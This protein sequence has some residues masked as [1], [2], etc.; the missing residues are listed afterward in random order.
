[1][2]KEPRCVYSPLQIEEA[3]NLLKSL[4]VKL[5]VTVANKALSLSACKLR[6]LFDPELVCE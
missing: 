1:M 4:P 5:L 6:F 3:T 2:K